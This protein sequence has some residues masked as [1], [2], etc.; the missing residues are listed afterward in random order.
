M[1]SPQHSEDDPAAPLPPDKDHRLR[2][3]LE[4]VF[5]ARA[6][7]RIEQRRGGVASP[8]LARSR[9]RTLEALEQYVAELDDLSYPVPRSLQQEIRLHRSLCAPRWPSP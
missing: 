6:S 7:E 9:A 4:A 8:A 2:G 3:L 5:A 1:T